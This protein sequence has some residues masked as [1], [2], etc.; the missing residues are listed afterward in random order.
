MYMYREGDVSCR[1]T[2]DKQHSLEVP[3]AAC[4]MMVHR[5]ALTREN[6]A[7]EV[8][9]LT[10]MPSPVPSVSAFPSLP[11]ALPWLWQ[12]RESGSVCYGR[13]CA[14]SYVRVIVCT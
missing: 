13:A 11:W 2:Q 4:Q 8:L 3:S 9:V 10:S 12:L 14:C 5:R 7:T 6:L 1:H